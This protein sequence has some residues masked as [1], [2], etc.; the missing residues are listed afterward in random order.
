VDNLVGNNKTY[1]VYDGQGNRRAQGSK[2]GGSWGFVYH[3]VN[4]NSVIPNII[5]DADASFS[6]TK[7]Y[8]Y[9][10]DLERMKNVGGSSYYYHTDGMGSVRALTNAAQTTAGSY[11]YDS[12]GNILASSGSSGNTYNFTGERWD[13][14]PGLLYLRARYYDPETGRFVTRDPIGT[15]GGI[16]LYRYCK[17]NPVNLTDPKGTGPLYDMYEALFSVCMSL[18]PGG[19]TWVVVTLYP[20]NFPC[21]VVPGVEVWV[22]RTSNPWFPCI[23]APIPL[24]APYHT[25]CPSMT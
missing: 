15:K 23:F 9:G 10:L 24:P 20:P 8:D 2:A 18:Q 7:R 5:A 4:A 14:D 25:C 16:N 13:A 3:Y 17:N 1:Y 6:V 11:L 22:R 21:P 12:F 19:S